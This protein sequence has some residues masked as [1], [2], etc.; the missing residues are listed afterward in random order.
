MIFTHSYNNLKY[1]FTESCNNWLFKY[2]K[3]CKAVLISAHD[4][5]MTLFKLLYTAYKCFVR[6][7]K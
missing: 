5:I 3:T 4:Y 7:F 1:V 6:G 2:Q